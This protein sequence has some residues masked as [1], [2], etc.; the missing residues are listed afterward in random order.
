[1]LRLGTY[2]PLLELASGGMATVYIARQVGAAGFERIVVIK[3]V[4]R[5]LLG[6]RDFYDMFRDEARVASMV[7]HPNVVSVIDVVEVID[8]DRELFLVMEYVESSA[9]AS[10]RKAAFEEGQRLPVPVVARVLCDMLAGL[11]AAHTAVDM[12]GRALD[13]VHRDVSPQNVIVG[14]DGSARLIDFGV[15]KASHRLTE[16]KSGSMKGKYSYMSP[17]QACGQSV[18]RRT[19]IFA[20]GIVLHECLTDRRLFRGQN[21]LDTVRRIME[22]EIVPPST[23]QPGIPAAVDAVALKALNRAPEGRYQTA[24]EMME[25]LET[26]IS[27]ASPRE[28][29]TYVERMCGPRLAERRDAVREML[30]G[31]LAPLAID[32]P[33]D[34]ESQPSRSLHDP[35]TEISGTE[36]RIA[37]ESTKQREPKSRFALVVVATMAVLAGAA[38]V[39]TVSS[40]NKHAVQPQPP[41]QEP[42]SSA[43]ANSVT[44]TAPTVSA[45]PASTDVI[46]EITAD[47]PIEGV[48]VAGSKRIELAGMTARVSLDPWTAPLKVDVTFDG[49][50]KG[51]V[52]LDPGT[53]TA[54]VTSKAQPKHGTTAATGQAT[55]KAELQGNPYG[56]P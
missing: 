10:L 17:E 46:V 32:L 41:K 2:E 3:R 52:M 42:T 7:R 55:A 14:V 44:A 21:E 39:L 4:H 45:A 28:V 27:P 11:H 16:T 31:H 23:L 5:H 38:L 22:G 30:A 20:A 29:A 56:T 6:H 51:T 35:A 26:A 50:K 25:A 33:K 9:L 54:H 12:H 1:M 37:V 43:T 13:I 36:G 34:T 47:A 40:T 24:L 15:A 8:P 49:N 53:T 19:D 18:D 48:R